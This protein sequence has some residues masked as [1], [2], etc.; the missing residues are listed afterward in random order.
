MLL[1][2]QLRAPDRRAVGWLGH[3]ILAV[4]TPLQGALDEAAE[5]GERWWRALAEIRALRVE[6]ARLRAEVEHLRRRLAD[7]EE[8]RSEVVRLRRLLDLRAELPTATLAARV[9]A[10]DPDTWFA[11]VLINRGGRHGVRRHDVVV[12]AEGLVG[13]VLEVY[14]TASRVLLVSDPRSAVG[15]LVQR[16]RDPA[17]VEGQAGPLLRLRYLPRDA[18][19]RPGDVL[20]TSGLGGVFPR[21]LRV[22]IIRSVLK[23]GLF[24]EAEVVPAADLSRLEEVLLLVGTGQEP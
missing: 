24:L 13:R 17:I 15:V 4:L 7:L 9:V 5:T 10:R 18:T 11:T 19:A 16:T 1:T 2:G 3:A 6:N 20:V 8:A 22:G 14:P 21:G 23:G 12:T